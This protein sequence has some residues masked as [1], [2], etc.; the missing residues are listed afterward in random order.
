MSSKPP[1]V[2][3]ALVSLRPSGFQLQIMDDL[4]FSDATCYRYV[5]LSD[6]A[7]YDYCLPNAVLDD[8]PYR[9]ACRIL[10]R[11]LRAFKD[12]DA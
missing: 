12:Y 6:G 1:S 4:P 10:A 9:M 2:S 7:G 3:A 5:R 11:V 8:D